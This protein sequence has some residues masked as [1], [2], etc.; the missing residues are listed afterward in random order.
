ML[1]WYDQTNLC[2]NFDMSSY[3][4]AK[5][6]LLCCYIY[7]FVKYILCSVF[8]LNLLILFRWVTVKKVCLHYLARRTKSSAWNYT[9]SCLSTCQMSTDFKP[10]TS[11][12]KTYS[13]AV[14]KAVL[15]SMLPM[16]MSFCK[17][18]WHAWP[19]RKSSWH[20]WNQSKK[21]WNW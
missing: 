15:N 10:L 14:L 6:N 19:V 5:T 7:Q 11:Y 4:N 17:T 3:V 16:L 20:H 13:M 8:S 2:L 9:N 1:L 12:V 21:V 18:L